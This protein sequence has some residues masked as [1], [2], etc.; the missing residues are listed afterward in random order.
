MQYGPAST[1]ERSATRIPSSGAPSAGGTAA[2]GSRPGASDVMACTTD[3]AN[4]HEL[5]DED[6]SLDRLA[7]ELPVDLPDASGAYPRYRFA[8]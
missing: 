3:R 7:P 8:D 1:L 6:G 4:R 2:G 5:R